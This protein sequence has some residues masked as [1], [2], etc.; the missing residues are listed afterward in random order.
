L[1]FSP[2]IQKKTVGGS[3]QGRRVEVRESMLQ[4]K[5]SM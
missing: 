3:L 1:C 2:T 5:F 4:W